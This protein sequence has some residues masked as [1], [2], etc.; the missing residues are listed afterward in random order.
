MYYTHDSLCMVAAS[1][2]A[3]ATVTER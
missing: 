2:E 3:L 1:I